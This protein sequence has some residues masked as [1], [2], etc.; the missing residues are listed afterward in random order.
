MNCRKAWTQSFVVRQLNRSF[1]INDYK[2]HRK[3]LLTEVELARMPETMPAAENFKNCEIEE[4]KIKNFEDKITQLTEEIKLMK[5]EQYECKRKIR[6]IKTGKDTKEDSN[7][8]I[9]P[10]PSTDCRGYLSSQYK[11]ELCKTFTCPKCHDI[12]GLSKNEEHTCN[13]DNIASAELIK[14]DTKPCPSCGTRISKISGCDQMWCIGCHQ[15]FSWRSGKIE[16]G[17]INNQHY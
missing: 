2:V 6:F 17:T 12:I 8:F 3:E 7:K 9:M 4:L 16:N 1:I 14:K 15:A 11:C 13:H 5:S 10:C